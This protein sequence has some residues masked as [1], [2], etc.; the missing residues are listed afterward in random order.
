M[1]ALKSNDACCHILS[2]FN[3]VK[4][5]YSNHQKPSIS[6]VGMF[7]FKASGP[8]RADIG[9]P[10]NVQHLGHV[11]ADSIEALLMAAK[12]DPSL[13][14]SFLAGEEK[15]LGSDSKKVEAEPKIET[16]SKP[17]DSIEPVAEPHY[18]SAVK[19]SPETAVTSEGSEP[20]DHPPVPARRSRPTPV[21]RPRSYAETKEAVEWEKFSEPTAHAPPAVKPKPKTKPKPVITKSHSEA[22]DNDSREVDVKNE[23]IK[24]HPSI[25][26][27]PPARPAQAAQESSE[28]NLA[29][30]VPPARRRKLPPTRPMSVPNLPQYVLEDTQS[31]R[32]DPDDGASAKKAG[33]SYD[34]DRVD[35]SST[36]QIV[37]K[38]AGPPPVPRRVDLE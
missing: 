19:T 31:D 23:R 8:G 1:L 26:P 28:S 14:P 2:D 9:M 18:V 6:L 10:F 25:R 5:S 12:D 20:E 33:S 11:G 37:T 27:L 36:S 38:K 34:I 35:E 4:H 13:L 32:L 24:P 7:V 16:D 17:L 3:T 29:A 21:P 15:A 30:P 22:I